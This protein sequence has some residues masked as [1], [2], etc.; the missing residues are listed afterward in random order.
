MFG[1]VLTKK[2]FQFFC[3]LPNLHWQKYFLS[4]FREPMMEN[5]DPIIPF[6]FVFDL[7]VLA[8][9]GLNKE[10]PTVK[11]HS[12]NDTKYKRQPS[13]MMNKNWD[14]LP[15][16]SVC[17]WQDMLVLADQVAPDVGARAYPGYV[18][19]KDRGPVPVLCGNQSNKRSGAFYYY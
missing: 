1:V 12:S 3:L 17:W 10:R 5:I 16:P 8:V 15:S 14:P 13:W 4:I 2:S 7:D 6:S 19:K 11:Y 9:V 18:M